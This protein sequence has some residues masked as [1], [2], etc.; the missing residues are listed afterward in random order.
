MRPGSARGRAQPG[1]LALALPG[2]VPE[3]RCPR[4][5]PSGHS[6]AAFCCCCCR[7]ECQPLSLDQPKSR[8]RR[9]PRCWK[10]LAHRCCSSPRRLRP[11]QA[12]LA[13]HPAGRR[14]PRPSPAEFQ[15]SLEMFGV[16]IFCS[17]LYESGNPLWNVRDVPRS[18]PHGFCARGE[19]S[20]AKIPLVTSNLDVSELMEDKPAR[21][22]CFIP[23]CP[24]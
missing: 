13:G 14:D 8:S 22:A 21:V 17:Y 2:A 4:A 20:I 6:P 23:G 7:S 10:G 15:S 9:G 24:T 18:D 12:E 19:F 1:N 11:H 5:L 16:F 3:G